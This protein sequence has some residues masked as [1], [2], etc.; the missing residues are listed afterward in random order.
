MVNREKTCDLC[1][2]NYTD[3]YSYEPICK[4][5]PK[6]HVNRINGVSKSYSKCSAVIAKCDE[7]D[8][9]KPITSIIDKV[10]DKIIDYEGTIK[11]SGIFLLGI[12]SGLSPFIG[13]LIVITVISLYITHWLNK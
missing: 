3:E 9:F 1:E 12:I 11:L 7:E 5:Y 4:A 2:Y 10:I 13:V 8:K 6:E